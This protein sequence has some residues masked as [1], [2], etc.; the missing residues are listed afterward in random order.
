[1]G[2]LDFFRKSAQEK[3]QESLDAGLQDF[4]DTVPPVPQTPA[5]LIIPETPSNILLKPLKWVTFQNRHVGIV[6]KL[7]SSNYATIDFVDAHGITVITD[8]V[9]C[10]D[11][12]LAKYLEI[13]ESRRPKDP[14]Y[15]ATLGYV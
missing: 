8:R 2:F 12:R 15:A 10:N 13:P 6:T 1:M 5:V 9:N 7:D 11:I 14:A 4:K 3:E